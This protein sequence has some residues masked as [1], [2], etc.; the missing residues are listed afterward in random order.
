MIPDQSG[1]AGADRLLAI[2]CERVVDTL[3]PGLSEALL[4]MV[5]GEKTRFWIPPN[6][7]DSPGPNP[8]AFVFD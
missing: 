5:I 6:L 1:N 4:R 8:M 7:A 2:A 3:I